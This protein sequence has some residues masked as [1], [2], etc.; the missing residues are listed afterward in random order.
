MAEFKS[1][2]SYFDF[3]KKTQRESRYIHDEEIYEFLSTLW[4]TSNKRIDEIKKDSR[5]YRA[6]LG[7]DYNPYYQDDVHVCDEEAPFTANRMKPLP[8]RASEGRA[9]PK[10]IPHLYLADQKETAMSEVRPWVGSKVTL[11]IFKII[12]DL[13]VVN[14]SNQSE[15]KNTICLEEPL[16]EIREEI[17]WSQIDN[18]FSR[19]VLPTDHTADYIPTQII[20][21]FFKSK[22]ID[23]IVYKSNLGS[24]LNFVLFNLDDAEFEKSRV[25]NTESIN[26]KFELASGIIVV[27]KK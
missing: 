8:D 7:C 6:Q 5:L 25:F 26:A 16:P 3:S 17:I 9:N 24:G 27:K 1:Y 13:R 21:E 20:T 12:R 2:R 14:F 10:G 11:A 4:E 15:K 22:G 23:G 19:P 18:A